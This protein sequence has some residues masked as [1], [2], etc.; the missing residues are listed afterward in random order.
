VGDP[1]EG[2]WVN[3]MTFC[4]APPRALD[5]RAGIDQHTVQVKEKG[6]TPEVYTLPF[7]QS[8]LQRCRR[9]SRDLRSDLGR[10]SEFRPY[11]TLP[12]DVKN[13]WEPMDA[14]A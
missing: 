9:T 6:L 8:V 4:P 12:L 1:E 10:R 11:P 5:D 2:V 3:L 14:N 7:L 13:R